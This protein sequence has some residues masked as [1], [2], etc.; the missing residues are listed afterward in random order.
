[1]PRTLSLE[2]ILHSQGFGSRKLCRQ[3]IRAGRVCVGADLEQDPFRE[4]SLQDLEFSVDG[5]VWTYREKAYVMLHKPAGFECSRAPRHHPG[6]LSL[7]PS[8][9][10]QRG[11]QP[12]GRLDVDTTGL[13]LLTDD[14]AFIH[15]LI[16]PRYGIPKVYVVTTKHP[17]S[18]TQIQALLQGVVLHDAPEPVAALACVPVEPHSLR[19]TLGEGRYHQVR[20]MLAAVGNRVEGLVRVAVGGLSLPTD[21]APGGWRWLTPEEVDLVQSAQAMPHK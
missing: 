21:L 4:L 1:M 3:I 10:Q 14:G 7:L 2:R 8:A 17:I 9:L 20:R 5:Q 15:R 6:V 13:L 18:E 12:V 11:V 16:S 19:M